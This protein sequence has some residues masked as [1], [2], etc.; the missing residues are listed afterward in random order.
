MKKLIASC[1]D[2]VM[3]NSRNP[4]RHLNLTSQLRVML[5]LAWMWS[6]VF[7]LGFLSIFAF[8]LTWAFHL[9]VLAGIG[10]TVITFKNEEEQARK[11]EEGLGLSLHVSSLLGYVLRF[12]RALIRTQSE[13]Q[14]EKSNCSGC[15]AG[16]RGYRY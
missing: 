13:L 9:L 10:F 5:I 2:A 12:C 3:N 14:R 4:L 8:G 11:R 15:H 7:S 16:Q 6:M 1:W